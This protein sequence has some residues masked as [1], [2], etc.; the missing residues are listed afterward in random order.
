MASLINTINE[1]IEYKGKTTLCIYDLSA[2][3][4]NVEI[5]KR[6]YN[7]LIDNNIPLYILDMSTKDGISKYSTAATNKDFKKDFEPEKYKKL[8]DNITEND[9]WK[10]QGRSNSTPYKQSFFDAFFLHQTYTIGDKEALLLSSMSTNTFPKKWKEL[11][12]NPYSPILSYYSTE[13]SYA[14]GQILHMTFEEVEEKWFARNGAYINMT[15]EEYRKLPRRVGLIPDVVKQYQLA[16][17]EQP[18]NPA[19]ST[20]RH[21]SIDQLKR[22]VQMDITLDMIME[23][24][25]KYGLPL[26]L[27]ETLKKYCLREIAAYEKKYRSY[28]SS[29]IDNHLCQLILD[30]YQNKEYPQIDH[31]LFMFIANPDK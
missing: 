21:L 15:I 19:I 28:M 4:Y 31:D 9:I 27:P 7:S 20:E 23:M 3:G 24:K 11:D 13:E 16:L 22:L 17:V 2:I 18:I 25:N 6:I 30:S 26:I 10:W 1:S 29:R 8:I 14:S 5:V 12:F